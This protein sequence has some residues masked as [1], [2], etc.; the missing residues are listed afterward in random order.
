M[1]EHKKR[2][3]VV[4]LGGGP[5]QEI[6]LRDLYA[7]Y[8]AFTLLDANPS[9]PGRQWTER[10]F[11]AS[12]YDF[13]ACRDALA[14][15]ITTE[16]RVVTFATGPAGE[17]CYRLCQEFE[18]PRRSGSLAAA[19]NN[20][21]FLADI[22]HQNGLRVPKQIVLNATE[23]DPGLLET[24]TFPAVLKPVHG[25][26]GR[27]VRIVEGR[28]EAIK[29]CQQ[30]RHP[31]LM[32]EKLSGREELLW[33]IIRQG[34]VVALLH[35]QNLFDESTGWYSPLGLAIERIPL[36]YGIPP[37][38]T[39]LAFQLVDVFDLQDDSIVAE[40]FVDDDGETIID[41][42]LNGLSAFACS[43]VLEG[44]L[45][46]SLLVDSY[47]QRNFDGP[48]TAG[49]VSCMAFFAAAEPT[50]LTRMAHRVRNLGGCVV[51]PPRNIVTLQ[52]FGRSIYKG[53]YFIITDAC[54]LADAAAKGR[55]I[56]A[57]IAG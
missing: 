8:G 24:M 26:G 51:E 52:C 38:W 19:A 18:L 6:F 40:L 34:R 23:F 12:I 49:W 37:R 10:F 50:A 5:S 35:G 3:P 4:V 17:V 16:S 56:L 1:A 31:F 36:R 14:S 32:Q 27:G 55:A 53:G 48:E 42:E 2:T 43:K 20:K 13:A 39:R 25:G 45:L 33:L 46:T 57:E 41:V 15:F 47:L 11:R 7:R 9:A 54:D 22:L 44:N 28:D 21:T 30:L 29:L